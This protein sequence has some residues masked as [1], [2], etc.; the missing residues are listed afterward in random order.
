M[1]DPEKLER[2]RLLVKEGYQPIGTLKQGS[3][4]GLKQP[5][6][7]QIKPNGSKYSQEDIKAFQWKD[8]QVRRMAA[9]KAAAMQVEAFA[10]I[11]AALKS[12]EGSTPDQIKGL[13]Q[14]IKKAEYF[15]NLDMLNKNP[16]K[17]DAE[18]IP[19]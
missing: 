1:S 12:W 11:C 3:T 19:F 18:V 4:I 5:E 8:L 13:L 14:S 9:L 10:R 16:E 17:D 2:M 6:S 7:P 15:D